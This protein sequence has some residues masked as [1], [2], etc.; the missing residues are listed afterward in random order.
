[1]CIFTDGYKDDLRV[2]NTSELYRSAL[3]PVSYTHLDVYKRQLIRGY[4]EKCAKLQVE[5]N[6]YT[7]D[8]VMDYLD[9]E[10]QKQQTLSLIH[11]YIMAHRNK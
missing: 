5:L 7:I 9:G 8:E 3:E 4:Q 6:R 2:S 11:I 10:H 1:M